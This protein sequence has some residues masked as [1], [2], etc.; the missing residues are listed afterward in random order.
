[1]QIKTKLPQ[2]VHDYWSQFGDISVSFDYLVASF[3]YTACLHIP[4]PGEPLV[5]T[6]L[7]VTDEEYLATRDAYGHRRPEVSPSRI[8][9][10]FAELEMTPQRSTRTPLVDRARLV[11]RELATAYPQLSALTETFMRTLEELH[12]SNNHT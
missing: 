4:H 11:L 6:T 8:L 2:S 9:T 1:M 10:Y 3:D 7:T 12:D 5:A